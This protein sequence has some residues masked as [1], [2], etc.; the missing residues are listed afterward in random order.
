MKLIVALALLVSSMSIS[1]IA[2]ADCTNRNTDIT[3]SKPDN[4]YTDHGDGT[5]TDNET[6]LMWKKCTL[7]LSGNDCSIGSIRYRPWGGALTTANS[8]SDH[9]YDDWRLPNIKELASLIENACNDP[10]INESIFPNTPSVSFWASSPA[11]DS[12]FTPWYV[13]FNRGNIF[14]IINIAP[15]GVRLVRGGQ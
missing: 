14:G 13:E 10:A 15:A 11:K 5:V 4:I 1:M 8:N 12:A 2:L 9:G 3:L 6:G 7:G